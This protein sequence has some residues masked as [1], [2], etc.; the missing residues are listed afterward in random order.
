MKRDQRF[1]VVVGNPPYAQMSQNLGQAQRALVD[2]YRYLDGVRIRERGAITFERN[3]QDDYVKFVR[4][5]ETLI[6]AAGCG[7]TGLVTNHGFLSILT[8]RGMRNHLLR[9]YELVR[10]LDLHGNSKI[11]EQAPGDERDENVFDIQQGVAVSL[12]ARRLRHAGRVVTHG[13]L[14]GS[15]EAKYLALQ[16][17][18]QSVQVEVL[19]PRSPSYLLVPRDDGLAGEYETW[20]GLD[21]IFITLGSAITTGRDGLVVDFDEE[22]VVERVKLL[23][24]PELSNE[25]LQSRLG[26]KDS[27]IWSIGDAATDSKSSKSR[28]T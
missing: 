11:G 26:L 3:L 21:D 4:M 17:E 12:L 6:A 27:A 14:W 8:L 1:T 28:S 20:T 16:S 7:V 13:E 2:P 25:A 24:D 23:Q 10:V 5:A 19:T 15:R 18:N 22:P 9:T